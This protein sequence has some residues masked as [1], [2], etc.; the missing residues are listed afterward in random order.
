MGALDKPDKP[1]YDFARERW[2]EFMFQPT[3]RLEIKMRAENLAWAYERLLSLPIQEVEAYADREAN[4]PALLWVVSNTI[5]RAGKTGKYS[6]IDKMIDRIIGKAPTTIHLTPEGKT[7]RAVTYS[8]FCIRAGY[9]QPFPKQIEMMEYGIGVPGAKLILGSRGY[10]KTDY[11]VILGIAWALFNDPTKT[12][13]VI[14]KSD[15]RNRGII[16]E[17]LHALE[18]NN[19]IIRDK[20]GNDLSVEG[21]KGKDPSVSAITLGSKSFRGRHP[22]IAIMDDP[23]TPEDV[24][25][26]AARTAA[27]TMYFEVCKLTSNI[28]IIGQ[29]AHKSD[30]YADLRPKLNLLEVPHGTIPELD[31]DLVAMKLA[32]VSIE[33]IEMS[34]HLRVPTTSANPLH[35]IQTCPDFV[36]GDCVAFIDPSFKGGDYTAMTVVRQYFDGVAVYGRVWKKAWYDS[37]DDILDVAEDKGVRRL[38]VETNSLGDQPVMVLRKALSERDIA[39]GVVGW[40]TTSNK[41]ARIMQL[42]AFAKYIYVSEDS[43]IEYRKQVKDYEYGIKNDDAPDS[44]ATCLEW[45]GLVKGPS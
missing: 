34:Y 18:S 6:E 30:L 20:V 28:L 41:H 32:G 14:T 39:C 44:L 9:P 15:T 8:E 42:G 11:V 4:M 2:N 16:K 21:Q 40:T 45:V 5:L 38:A 37:I 25:S 43:D 10:G 33:S 7:A 22:D 1:E 17:I 12:F 26:L 3:M 31:H 29:P 13:L 27:Q 19:V 24:Q 36:P 23:V 35:G